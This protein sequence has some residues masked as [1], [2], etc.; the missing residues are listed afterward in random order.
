VLQDSSDT[1]AWQKVGG[2]YISRAL[3]LAQTKA[4]RFLFDTITISKP[5]CFIFQ[6]L[7]GKTF[8]RN[9]LVIAIQI[10]EFTHFKLHFFPGA[11]DSRFPCIL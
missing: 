2:R 8:P 6:K 7:K 11:Q 4:S 3:K 9:V 1:T 10:V 5:K